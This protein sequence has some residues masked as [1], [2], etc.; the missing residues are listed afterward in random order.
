MAIEFNVQDEISA[1]HLKQYR[2]Y[3]SEYDCE[4]QGL[5]VYFLNGM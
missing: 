5:H 4:Y 3:G 1:L 2:M